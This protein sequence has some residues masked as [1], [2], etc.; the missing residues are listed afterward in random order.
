MTREVLLISCVAGVLL[1]PTTAGARSGAPSGQTAGPAAKAAASVQLRTLKPVIQLRPAPEKKQVQPLAARPSTSRVAR[2]RQAIRQAPRKLIRRIREAVARPAALKPTPCSSGACKPAARVRGEDVRLVARVRPMSRTVYIRRSR[3][4][5]SRL[6][7]RDRVSAFRMLAS[8]R[9]RTSAAAQHAVLN[10]L[11]LRGMS[12]GQALPISMTDFGA[13]VRGKGWSARR[14]A[15]F[16]LV[17]RQA[18]IIA[19]RERLG[20]KQA[21]DKA[22]QINGIYKQYYSGRCGA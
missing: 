8:R 21:F 16:A 3:Q 19:R 5:L 10:Y 1:G 11:R 4:V 12:G 15:N 14:M 13:M 2:F 17:L 18:S 9:V 7:G 22:L 6:R 20:A